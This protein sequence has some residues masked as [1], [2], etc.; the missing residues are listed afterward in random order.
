[1]RS[2][3]AVL[4][5]DARLVVVATL[6]TIGAALAAA[7]VRDPLYE[8]RAEIVVLPAVGT[9]A[10]AGRLIPTEIRVLTS[11]EVRALA[12]DALG[13]SPTVEARQVGQT[14]VIRVT[15]TAATAKR[16][17]ATAKVYAAAYVDFR[18]AGAAQDLLASSREVEAQLGRLTE[19]IG[20][21][22]GVEKAGL[23]EQYRFF[24]QV[25]VRLQVDAASAQSRARLVSPASEVS[26]LRPGLVTV[27][28]WAALVGLVLGVDFAVLFHLLDQSVRSRPDLE[29]AAGGVPVVGEIPDSSTPA[30][31]A[32]RSLQTLLLRARPDLPVRV[33]LVASPHGGD[34][35]TTVVVNFGRALAEAGKRVTVVDADLRSPS[36]HTHFG[37]R[38]D[39]GLTSMARHMPLVSALQHVPGHARLRVLTSGPWR[40]NPQGFLSSP[41]PAAA[42]EGVGQE[43]DVVL[44]DCPPVLEVA[45]ALVLSRLVDSVLLI[46]ASNQTT[47]R[48]VARAVEQLRSV[49]APLAG[50]VLN[51]AGA[52]VVPD[53]PV[54]V[55]T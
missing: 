14:D 34:G 32:Y 33:V 21:S 48:D 5:A 45:D 8:G 27:G 30:T 36:L 40:A 47:R 26:A 24:S 12:A 53:G 3:L 39:V 29:R 35:R 41:H 11:Q 7:S 51:R 44:V 6:V 15:A 28:A 16:A 1:M 22:A 49:G 9:P 23:E 4:R 13:F 20:G 46:A 50:V 10:D 38:N 19:R 54:V 37:L 43:A 18:K 2:F 17:S 55:R 42:L 25:Q 52:N 31:E